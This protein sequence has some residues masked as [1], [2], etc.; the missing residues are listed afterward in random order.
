MVVNYNDLETIRKNNKNKKIA[1]CRGTFDLFHYSHL[2]LFK[3]IKDQVDVLVVVV[4]SDKDV[5]AKKKDRPI[6]NEKERIEIVDSIKYVDYTI[7]ASETHTTNLINSVIENNL[8]SE[9]EIYKL[10]RDG[11]ILEKVKPDFIYNTSEYVI[12]NTTRI[13]CNNLN[14]QIKNIP[15]QGNGVH[16][17][18]II[19][20]IRNN[21]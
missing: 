17:T 18:D 1:I 8:F 6:I 10:K 13:M 4:K 12:T 2:M 20:K 3:Y 9:K 14:I 15:V 5:K 7:L 19:N 21:Y 11:Y 16:T